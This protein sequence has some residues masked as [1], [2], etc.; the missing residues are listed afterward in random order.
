MY[1]LLSHSLAFA[2]LVMASVYDLLTSE[3]PD[4][5]SLVG[6]FG[7]V[8][9]H[10]VYSWSVGSWEPLMWSLVLGFGFLAYGWITY[11]LGLWGGADAMAVGVLGFAAPFGL[12]SI[13]F[14]HSVNLLVNILFVGL[15][16]SVVFSLYMSW[17]TEGF[18][19]DFKGVLFA[20]RWRICSELILVV[21]FSL[22]MSFVGL[23]GVFW[24]FLLGGSVF[25]FRYLRL[26]EDTVFEKSVSV[27]NVDPGEVVESEELDGRIKGVT[28]ED[29]DSLD[30]DE[31]VVK[32]GIRFIP[33]FPLALL[34]TD[35]FGGGIF[36]I[37]YLTGV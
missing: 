34:V 15:V 27:E 5:V 4:W 21:L 22:Y 25:L 19:G 11:L 36:L 33:V 7:G 18:F 14:L 1:I 30:A 28:E 37:Q 26:V 35:V 13:G 3:V 17:N 8:A 10:G 2:V 9:L 20:D 23:N 29:L 6:M 32:K 12:E 31:V 16:Y 24:L